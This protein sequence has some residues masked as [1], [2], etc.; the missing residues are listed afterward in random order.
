MHLMNFIY[1][2]KFKWR[3]FDEFGGSQCH[4]RGMGTKLIYLIFFF[5]DVFYVLFP[6]HWKKMP[7]GV[8]AFLT[9]RNDIA[10]CAL[11][12]TRDRYDMVHGQFFWSCRAAAVVAGAFGAAAL[13]PLRASEFSGLVPFPVHF[14]F[15]QIVC[16][17]FH[18]LYFIY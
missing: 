1:L 3:A 14:F 4:L 12:A 6:F 9:R 17:R 7:F 11:A 10:L 2:I 16:E 13:P 5:F 18:F 15:C 8:V